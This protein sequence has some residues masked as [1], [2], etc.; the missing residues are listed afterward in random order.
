MKISIVTPHAVYNYGAVLQAHALYNYL[1]QN[2]HE[3]YMQDFPPHVGKAPKTLK[4]KLY[5]YA[6]RFF[7]RCHKKKIKNGDLSF[8]R[9][10][11]MFETTSR[12]DM[13][14]YIVGSDQVWNPA[15]LDEIFSLEFASDFSRKISYAASMGVDQIPRTQEE[16]YR[17]M[18]ERLERLSAREFQTAQEIARVSGRNCSVEC[19]PT[20]LL[21]RA[22]WAKQ[23]HALNIKEPYILLYLLHIPKDINQI[24]AKVKKHYG[25]KPLII[26]R[27]GFLHMVVRGT[28]AVYECGP[29]EFLW[30]INHAKAVITSS[31]HGTAF[32]IIFHKEF[33]SIVNPAS[34]SRIS[35]LLNICGL[36]SRGIYK[37]EDIDFDSIDFETVDM[38][39]SEYVGSSKNYLKFAIGD[40]NDE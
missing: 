25:C 22:E 17:V 40:I 15:N 33:Y 21:T 1:L 2:G 34:P 32:S 8:D 35:N 19:D 3:V 36:S 12:V 14:L 39:L 13:P 26:D 7:K 37:V 28:K 6:S 5:T 38:K 20:F 11:G 31:F 30:L 10:I 4:E 23:E 9:F 16:Q 27:T 24:V 29:Q 18:L